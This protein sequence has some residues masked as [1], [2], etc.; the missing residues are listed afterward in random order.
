[1]TKKKNKPRTDKPQHSNMDQVRKYV[2]ND[3]GERQAAWDC[4]CWLEVINENG[5]MTIHDYPDEDLKKYI[6]LPRK[7]EMIRRPFDPELQKELHKECY[8][9]FQAN[10]RYIARAFSDKGRE[11]IVSMWMNE[12]GWCM[13]RSYA[14]FIHIIS[15]HNKVKIVFGSLGYKKKDGSVS[16]EYG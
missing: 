6:M 15:T 8:K 16:W 7:A 5:E 4:H 2:R 14:E 3:D 11:D 12:C 9:D 10:L 13:F 1:M